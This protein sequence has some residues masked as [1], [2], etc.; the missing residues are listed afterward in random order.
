MIKRI[1]FG[2]G[3]VHQIHQFFFLEK[4]I[5]YIKS[6]EGRNPWYTGSIQRGLGGE[7]RRE[8]EKIKKTNHLRGQICHDKLL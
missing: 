2:L 3:F 6:A 4:S 8:R 1:V 7:G 5:E